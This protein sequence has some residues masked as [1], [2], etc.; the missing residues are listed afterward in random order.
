MQD[1]KQGCG[2]EPPNH[3]LYLMVN[4]T[5]AG[6][7]TMDALARPEILQETIK[8]YQDAAEGP[9][10]STSTVTGF[11]PFKKFV[12]EEELEATIASIERI[13]NQTDY[14]RWQRETI[15]AHLRDEQSANL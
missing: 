1:R 15:V 2:R 14:A 3:V 5:K 12:T 4:Q 10:T 6:I 13:E 8:K 11:F 7:D 9:L